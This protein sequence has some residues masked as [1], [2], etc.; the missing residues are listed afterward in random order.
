MAPTYAEKRRPAHR[1]V[2]GNTGIP[3][4]VQEKFEAASGLSFDDVRIHY[5][6]PRPAKL[7]ALAY[8]QGTQVYVG[9]GQERHLEHELGHVLQQKRGLVRADGF[10]NGLPVNRDP[11]LERAADLGADQPA[12]AP[13]GR[14]KEEPVQGKAGPVRMEEEPVQGKAGPVQMK[15]EPV[16]GKEGPV[17]TEEEP[18]RTEEAS[19]WMETAP[20][21]MQDGFGF[22]IGNIPNMTKQEILAAIPAG[23]TRTEHGP[24]VH[25]RDG[26]GNIR[27]R[28]DPPD[29]VTDYPHVHLYDGAGNPLDA[30]GN[31][32]DRRDRAAHLPY[33]AE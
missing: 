3:G 4:A 26:D 19:G 29:A 12:Q 23:W 33:R 24:F 5:N 21:Q 11:A 17:R 25:V 18:V 16:Q 6:S 22:D 13:G 30:G 31:V 9:P 2:S 20:I 15:E 8:T 7:G 32:A 1:A 10:V 14:R 27:I 28:F